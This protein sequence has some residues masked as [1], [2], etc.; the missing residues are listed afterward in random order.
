M[1]NDQPL[2]VALSC[3]LSAFEPRLGDRAGGR[4]ELKVRLR[5][6][7]PAQTF[8]AR[9]HQTGRDVTLTLFDPARSDAGA[10]SAFAGVVATASASRISALELPHVPAASPSPPYCVSDP[11][12]ARSLDQLREGGADLPWQKVLAL[13][14]RLVEALSMVYGATH[15][16]HRALTPSRCV[17]TQDDQIRVLDYGVAEFEPSEGR[18]DDTGYRAPEQRQGPGDHRSDMYSLGAILFE[19]IAGERPSGKTAPRL[20]SILS[21]V[22]DEVDEFF[23]RA[24]ARDPAKRFGDLA[25]M[26][27]TMR[28]LLG[29]SAEERPERVAAVRGEVDRE[30]IRS[31]GEGALVPDFG[32]TNV[33]IE[34]PLSRAA[35]AAGP[36]EPIVVLRPGLLPSTATALNRASSPLL[37]DFTTEVLPA[38]PLPQPPSSAPAEPQLQR[39]V[40]AEPRPSPI[41]PPTEQ[42]MR[43]GPAPAPSLSP[44]PSA[45]TMSVDELPTMVKLSTRRTPRGH[46]KG[47]VA[48]SGARASDHVAPLVDK[49]EAV[50]CPVLRAPADKTEVLGRVSVRPPVDRTEVLSSQRFGGPPELTTLVLSDASVTASGTKELSQA[51]ET[52]L[53]Q[54]SVIGGAAGASA[55]WSVQKKLIA[56][57]LVFVAIILTGLLIRVML[58]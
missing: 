5:G 44:A 50:Q 25:V 14:E 31:E 2:Q 16:A 55:P 29:L 7:G 45:R 10:W 22:P 1:D 57:N 28:R 43:I 47:A 56:V 49:T 35:A 19:L 33:A 20:R 26:R 17:I 30:S 15:V 32:R 58:Q 12:R 21:G 38:A 36:A 46:S 40:R 3:L 37:P 52:S 51:E 42:V 48:D 41:D 53:P 34:P 27:A 54:M 18:P 39:R 23:A 6:S 24:L 4:Y 13:G 11:P 9:D 8:L